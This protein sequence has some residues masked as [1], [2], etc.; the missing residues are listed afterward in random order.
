MVDAGYGRDDLFQ[1]LI[2]ALRQAGRA[3]GML[4]LTAH[5]L[6]GLPRGL[7]QTADQL[8]DFLGG[9]ACTLCQ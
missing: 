1:G 5:R 9:P 2:G 3:F 7:L 4:D 6:H 8:L